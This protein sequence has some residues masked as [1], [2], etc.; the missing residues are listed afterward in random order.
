MPA[1]CVPTS[2]PFWLLF[3]CARGR[4]VVDLIGDLALLNLANLLPFAA[5][6]LKA[7][8]F[9]FASLYAGKYVDG[10]RVDGLLETDGTEGLEGRACIR[11]L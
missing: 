9:A 10:L 4:A 2:L 11:G 7:C 5:L 8:E 1:G 3:R 6:D